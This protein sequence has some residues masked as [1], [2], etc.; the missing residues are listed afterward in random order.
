MTYIG[1]ARALLIFINKY[2]PENTKF[3]C[4]NQQDL[5]GKKNIEI[6]QQQLHLFSFHFHLLALILQCLIGRDV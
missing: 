2:C 3:I 1:Q 4:V 6:F 5:K